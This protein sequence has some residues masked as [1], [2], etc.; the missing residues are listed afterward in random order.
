M[1][2]D[3][4]Y[5]GRQL[6]KRPGFTAAAIVTLGLGIGGAAAMFGLIQGVL[7]SPP[8]YADPDRLILLSPARL[9]RQPY[10]QGSTIGQWLDW[11]ASTRTIYPPALY[12]WT[13]NFLVLPVGSESLGGMVVSSDF[14]NILGL[15][16]VI[17]RDFT[18]AEASRPKVP[19]TAIIL[20][21]ISGNG[22]SMAIPAS[23]GRPSA[24]AGTLQ[25]CQWSG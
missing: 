14:F 5:A 18:S 3:I 6:R 13:F 1:I 20:V 4:R 10:L 7:L 11:R 12:R 25:R 2:E 22:D 21:T 23:S 19:P 16:P 17:G 15:T 24:S 8:P 9:D